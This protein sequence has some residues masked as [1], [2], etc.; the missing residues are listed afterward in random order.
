MKKLF[1]YIL[2]VVSALLLLSCGDF[3]EP[4]SKSE[5]VPKD[6]VSLNELLLGEAYPI[7]SGQYL[8]CF[9][10]VL[11]DDVEATGF[12]EVQVG[13][14]EEMWWA[15]YTWQ[16]NLYEIFHTTGPSEGIYNLYK[17]YYSLILGTN[18]VL[19][20]LPTVE[21]RD[22]DMIN[23]VAAQA[24][25]LRGFYYFNLVNI[26]GQPYYYNKESLGV[27]L[28]LTSG[29]ELDTPSRNTVAEVYEQVLN[30]LNNA[31]QHYNLLPVELQW[32]KNY[33]VSLP[34]VE[35]MLSRVYLYMENWTKAA[36]YAERVMNNKNFNMIDLNSVPLVNEEGNRSYRNYHSYDSPEVIWPYSSINDVTFLVARTGADDKVYFKASDA[37]METFKETPEDLRVDCYLVREEYPSVVDDEL[38]YHPQAFGKIAIHTNGYAP[39]GSNNFGRSLRVS[40][41]FLNYS[42][43]KAMLYKEGVDGSAL[44]QA[45][46]AVNRLRKNRFPNDSEDFTINISDPEELIEFVKRERRRELCFEDHRWFDLR[47]WGMKPFTHVWYPNESTISEFT[48]TQ[49]D[50][51]FTIPLP[52]EALNMNP[53]LEQNPLAPAPRVN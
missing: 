42:E 30:D 25:A 2:S 38:V 19:D 18:A 52:P 41:A 48:L 39:G 44:S 51:G 15:A 13:Q 9:L 16:S 43:A 33:R 17:N 37:L 46:N 31:E 12:H 45:L 1:I 49:D 36:E 40:E 21:D 32:R 22:Q 27:P 29:I 47:R 20:Y 14:N 3:L 28:K 5:F 34:M 11:D 4:R 24:Y 23:Q 8:N 35:L 53:N 6:A 26:F 7:N 10:N 50:L